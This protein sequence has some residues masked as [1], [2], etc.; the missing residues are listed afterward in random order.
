MRHMAKPYAI[1]HEIS[2]FIYTSKGNLSLSK[3]KI[4]LHVTK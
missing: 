2:T 1:T 4:R 3:M